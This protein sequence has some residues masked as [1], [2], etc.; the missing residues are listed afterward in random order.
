MESISKNDKSIVYK[1][2]EEEMKSS[3][4]SYAMSVIIGRALPDVRDGLKVVHRRILYSMNESGI[5]YEKPCKKSAR[6]VGDVLGKYHPHGDSSVYDAIVRM[7]QPF[8]LRYPLIYGQ[9]NFGSIDGDSAAAMRYTEIKLQ[10]ISSEILEDLNKNTV[11]FKGNYDNSIKE[12]VVLPSKIP[13]L[14]I[15]GSTGI[16][17]GMATNI[18]PHNLSEIV[19]G[20]IYYM[21]NKENI[22]IEK[23]MSIIKGPDFPT[24]GIILGSNGLKKAYETGRGVIKIRGVIKVEKIGNDRKKIIITEIPYQVNKSKIV[25]EISYCVH[26]KIISG[27]SDLRDESDRK[28]IRIVIEVMK[29]FNEELIINSLYK[30]T[31]LEISFGIINLAIVNSSPKILSLFNLIELYINYRLE[32]IQKRTEYE[33]NISKSRIHILKGLEIASLNI[34]D[35]VNIIKKSINID[36]L[37]KELIE[38]YNLDDVQIKSILELKLQKLMS[39]EYDHIKEEI[40]FHTKKINEYHKILNSKFE[41]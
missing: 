37:K 23:L 33:L 32:I 39:I 38:K 16:A 24:G 9:G 27:I 4:L 6:I 36:K 22:T 11:Q 31:Q 18:P 3:Y 28:G 2:I 30:H 25:E 8:S 14:L 15:N 17:V 5:T 20:I 35:I 7:V 41:K 1:K 12:P 26:E 19:D 13:N 29:G 40:L 10:K 21:Y 34:I